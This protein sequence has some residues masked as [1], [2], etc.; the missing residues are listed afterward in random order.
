MDTAVQKQTRLPSSLGTKDISG[1]A[2]GD[3][4]LTTGGSRYKE[5]LTS[6]R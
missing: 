1:Q 4:L 3:V 2:K 5:L 6:E